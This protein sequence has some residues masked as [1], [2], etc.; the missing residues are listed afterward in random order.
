MI[1]DW[2]DNGDQLVIMID[3]NEDISKTKIETSEKNRIEWTT[4]LNHFPSPT[5]KSQSFMISW[6][7]D[8]R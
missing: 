7:Q 5:P 6:F 3:T 1:V 2:V 4:L 8:D